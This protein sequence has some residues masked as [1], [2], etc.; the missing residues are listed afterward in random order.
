MSSSTAAGG[1][2]SSVSAG[3]VPGSVALA[4]L[5]S[6]TGYG[7][8][9]IASVA[10]Q[11]KARQFARLHQPGAPLL[12]FNAWDAGSARTVAEAGACA[13][14]TGSQAVAAAHGYADGQLLPLPLVM[15]NLQRILA[16][17]SLPVTLDLEAGYAR[18]AFDVARNVRDVIAAGAIGINLEDQV[19]GESRQFSIEAQVLRIAAVRRVAS[20]AGLDLFIN[21]RTDGFLLARSADHNQALLE[22]ALVRAQAYRDAGASGLFVPGLVDE[23]LLGELCARAP[24]PVNAMI[25]PG[26]PPVARLSALGVARVSYGG[27][28]HRMA[29]DALRAGAEEVFQ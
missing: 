18:D 7:P 6:A 23:T 29:M 14:A 16:A 17:V 3:S 4:S 15:A 19:L 8:K 20:D 12:L 21:A 28:P 27:T 25:M 24:L 26:C 10:Q 9:F 5:A 1:G 22:A 13:I 11:D 2:A